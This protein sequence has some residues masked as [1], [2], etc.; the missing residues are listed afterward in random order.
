MNIRPRDFEAVSSLWRELADLPAARNTE[1]LVHCM[2]KLRQI[3]GAC[4]VSWMATVRDGCPEPGDPM[5]GWD[6]GDI[7]VLH[8][9]DAYARRNEQTLAQ[10][11]TEVVDPQSAA[12]VA[13]AGTTRAVLRSAVLPGKAWERSW[14]RREILRPLGVDDRLVGSFPV[15]A[16]AESYFALDRA[17]GDR[18]FDARERDLLHLFLAGCPTFHREQL[19]VRGL[20]GPAVRLSPREKSVLELLLTRLS[21]QEMAEALGLSFHTVHQYVKSVYRK[22]Q[23]N[24]RAELASLWLGSSPAVPPS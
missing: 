2:E 10:F 13:G 14:L 16:T 17:A 1:A 22:L 9:A 11:A 5:Q 4:N 18:P 12:M 6:A 15:S 21:E 19:R 20:T 3:V 8:D 23:V 7:V 24:S